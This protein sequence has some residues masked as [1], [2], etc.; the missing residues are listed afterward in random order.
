MSLDKVTKEI[1]KLVVIRDSIQQALALTNYLIKQDIHPT[2]DLYTPM[3]SGIITTYMKNFVSSDGFGPLPQAYSKFTDRRME[4]I[5]RKMN[6]ARNSLYAHRENEGRSENSESIK[7]KVKLNGSVLDFVPYIVELNPD[8]L[9]DFRELMEFQLAR[10][11][12]DF[13]EKVSY[14]LKNLEKS[15]KADHTYILGETFP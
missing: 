8:L 13:N 4:N 14:I 5:H 1:R 10:I 6:I 7:V 2:D 9:K 11:N 3:M 12:V 15:Y